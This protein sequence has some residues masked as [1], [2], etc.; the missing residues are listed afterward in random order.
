MPGSR[1]SEGSGRILP[2][3]GRSW[4]WTRTRRGQIIGG[5][6]VSIGGAGVGIGS[7]CNIFIVLLLSVLLRAISK[8]KKEE[9]R[10]EEE[11]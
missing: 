9:G 7:R 8:N 2:T 5:V 1:P 11:G 3:W 4:R 6:V 10:E